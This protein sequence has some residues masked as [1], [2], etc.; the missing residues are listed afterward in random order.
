MT[1][2]SLLNS[3]ILAQVLIVTGASI[4]GALGWVHLL[5]TFFSHKFNAHNPQT[6]QAMKETSPLIS[7]QTSMWNA[8]VGFNASHSLGALLLSAVYIPLAIRHMALIELSLWFSLLPCLTSLCYLVLAKRYW[9]NLPF[10]GI[11]ISS[12]CFMTAFLVIHI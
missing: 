5:L 10:T 9:F 7:K 6:T 11:L 4:F 8:W 2:T 1:E 12:L 3:T